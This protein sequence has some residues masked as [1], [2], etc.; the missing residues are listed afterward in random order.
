MLPAIILFAAA[1]VLVLTLS[2][3]RPYIALA[4]GIISSFVDNV[5]T[6][7]MIVASFPSKCLLR[8]TA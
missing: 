7:L 8:P 3:Y 1:N 4:S 2:K 6:V 5:A